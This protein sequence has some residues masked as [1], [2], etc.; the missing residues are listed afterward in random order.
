LRRFWVA[1]VSL[2]EK[3]VDELLVQRFVMLFLT[4]RLVFLAWVLAYLSIEIDCAY[5][6][7][8]DEGGC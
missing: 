1:T 5:D 4:G 6:R 2:S 3:A 8:H 7:K